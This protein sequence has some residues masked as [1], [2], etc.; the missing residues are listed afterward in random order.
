MKKAYP[1]IYV[2]SWIVILIIL[3]ISLIW[4]LNSEMIDAPS[5]LIA[6]DAGIMAYVYW[7]AIVLLSTRPKWLEKYIGLPSMYFLHALVGVFALIAATYHKFNSFSL[8]Q[9][10]KLTG[11]IAWYLAIFGIIYAIFFMA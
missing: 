2:L 3:P 6:Y 4:L 9:N 5:R 8:D 7:L 11:N 10:V 1:I